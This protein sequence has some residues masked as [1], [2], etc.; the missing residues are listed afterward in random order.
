MSNESEKEKP[1]WLKVEE[2]DTDFKELLGE[3]VAVKP[4]K[5]EWLK[6]I[7]KEDD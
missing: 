7:E 2:V 5:K 3:P 1:K 4:D 6:K